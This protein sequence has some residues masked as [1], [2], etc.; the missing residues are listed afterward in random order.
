MKNEFESIIFILD[1]L[2]ELDYCQH[3]KGDIMKKRI[4]IS[5]AL[6]IVA[7]LGISVVADFRPLTD[8][9]MRDMV[10]GEIISVNRVYCYHEGDDSSGCPIPSGGCYV[11]YD[12]YCMGN[13]KQGDCTMYESYCDEY[14]ETGVC[15]EI[16]RT[17]DMGSTN[18]YSVWACDWND[19]QCVGDPTKYEG[20]Y[21]C[22][23]TWTAANDVM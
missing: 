2:S 17:C 1:I 20:T 16:T 22:P 12:E 14:W 10:G 7:G 5:A 9:E 18:Q 13:V 6:I 21:D 15:D 19:D 11:L 4:F 3:H 23:Y 8:S